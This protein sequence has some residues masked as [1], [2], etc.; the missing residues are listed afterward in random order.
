MGD[1]MKW[2]RGLRVV[3]AILASFAVLAWNLVQI[4]RVMGWL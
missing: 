3:A 4:G 1:L 2:G